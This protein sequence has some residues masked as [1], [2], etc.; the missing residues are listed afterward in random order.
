MN[1]ARR[2]YQLL[3]E[4]HVLAVVDTETCNGPDGDHI[5]SIAVTR[6]EEGKVCGTWS[7]LIDP[8]VPI[9]N[10]FI[11]HLTDADVV[12]AP[13]FEEIVGDLEREL[14]GGNLVLAAHHARFDVGK[15]HLEYGRLASGRKLPDLSVLDTMTLPDFLGHD[16]GGS[17][18]LTALLASFGLTN[19]KPHDAASDARCTAEVLVELLHVAARQGYADLDKLLAEVGARSTHDLP[20]SKAKAATTV[21]RGVASLSPE[22]LATHNVI[23]KGTPSRRQI[24]RWVEG[25]AECAELRCALLPDKAEAAIDYARVLHLRLTEALA[26][27]ASS[28]KRGQGATLVGAL[29]TL[30][31]RALKVSE[32]RGW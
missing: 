28:A 2:A 5:I 14:V 20:A 10:S 26:A 9:T 13:R 16:T 7:T 18:K 32:A 8:G 24:D 11:H 29:N 4:R 6:I 21:A 22:H 15:L 1:A 12:G 25:A 30:A 23:L 17:R 3:C 27:L 19:P 31:P